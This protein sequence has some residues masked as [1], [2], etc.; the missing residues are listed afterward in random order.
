MNRWLKIYKISQAHLAP[1]MSL[2]LWQA[3]LER[4]GIDRAGR[5]WR[6]VPEKTIDHII[7]DI[8]TI[9]RQREQPNEKHVKH[10]R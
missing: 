2:H 10:I 5:T 1:G 6:G 7:T 4:H 9:V 8:A 3:I